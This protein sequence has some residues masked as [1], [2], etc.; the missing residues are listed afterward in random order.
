MLRIST[1]NMAH[2]FASGWTQTIPS[3]SQQPVRLGS[4]VG[5][6]QKGPQPRL[7]PVDLR[8]FV[9][10]RHEHLSSRAHTE[11]LESLLQG[12]PL[13]SWRLRV[14]LQGTQVDHLVDHI[15]NSCD[16]KS[17]FAKSRASRWRSFA[18][19]AHAA[20]RAFCNSVGKCSARR[21]FEKAGVRKRMRCAPE[22][23]AASEARLVASRPCAVLRPC[24][25][26]DP[27]APGNSA[28]CASASQA[29]PD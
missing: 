13:R 29:R 24:R 11:I 23:D 17:S 9:G 15:E 21:P 8:Q 26:A 12:C 25:H 27:P 2:A 22:A 7:T 14:D 3:N 16:P 18:S 20:D 19:W 4:L 28:A 5:A 1:R 10:A 6:F